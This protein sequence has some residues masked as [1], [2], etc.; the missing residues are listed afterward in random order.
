VFLQGFRNIDAV[1][2]SRLAGYARCGLLYCLHY[3]AGSHFSRLGCSSTGSFTSCL[4]NIDD[5]R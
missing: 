5:L 2:V 4:Y 1:N 3:V